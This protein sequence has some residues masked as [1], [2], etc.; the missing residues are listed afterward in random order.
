M[1]DAALIAELELAGEQLSAAEADFIIQRDL[2]AADQALA[3]DQ[4][5]APA[6]T[7]AFA[8][9]SAVLQTD[10]SSQPAQQGIE[11]VQVALL[12]RALTSLATQ[13][14]EAAL[15]ALDDAAI[16]GADPATVAERRADAEYGQRLMNARAGIFE[17]I[18][19]IADL[20]AV[21]QE[22][23]NYPRFA[24]SG[25]EA[26]VD[27]EMTV[28][29]TGETTDIEV[30]G[31]APRYFERA[32]RKAVAEWRFEPVMVNGRPMPIRTTVRLTFRG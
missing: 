27:L 9:Y 25:A 28:T 7:S 6:G 5:M 23:P 8:L 10:D 19:A 29:E 21:S 4:L 15:A 13:D 17:E 20:T 2:V 26:S 18:H 11:A 3:R 14:F 1:A 24:P 32:A 12:D 30:L 16:A 22:P 31:D